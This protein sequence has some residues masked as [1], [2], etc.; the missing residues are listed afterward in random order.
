MF[1]GGIF[2]PSLVQKLRTH[3]L[4]Q[5]F[6]RALHDQDR[7][8]LLRDETT[9]K[10]LSDVQFVVPA[11]PAQKLQATLE[12]LRGTA[13]RMQ[14]Q[15]TLVDL[16]PPAS[17]AR[18]ARVLALA[19]M[20]DDDRADAETTRRRNEIHARRNRPGHACCPPLG[21][22]CTFVAVGVCAHFIVKQIDYFVAQNT[23]QWLTAKAKAISVSGTTKLI[24]AGGGT[25]SGASGNLTVHGKRMQE[26]FAWTVTTGLVVGGV[27]LTFV[28]TRAAIGVAR[29]V[30]TA[31]TTSSV[32]ARLASPASAAS[33][34]SAA[35]VATSTGLRSATEAGTERASA[36]L[37][38]LPAVLR[39]MPPFWSGG[40]PVKPPPNWP[41]R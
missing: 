33:K 38:P 5:G 22:I 2:E 13:V 14:Q 11:D 34:M 18:V 20:S 37:L 8:W 9:R 7:E 16:V 3:G 29:R 30:V 17:Q 15:G 40:V 26:M 28:A 27:A 25:D 32:A 10:A 31:A 23:S 35:P 24:N 6:L 36:L 12:R 1:D 21:T 41:G 39:A 19:E 4:I